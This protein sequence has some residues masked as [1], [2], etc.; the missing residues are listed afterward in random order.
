[1]SEPSILSVVRRHC[2]QGNLAAAADL[3][4]QLVRARFPL[5]VERVEIRQDG[6]SLNSVNGFLVLANSGAGRP[7]RLFFK[8]HQEEGEGDTIKEYYRGQLLKQH[9]F[10][11]DAP[12]HASQ[13]VGEQILIYA[14]RQC[15]RFADV[16]HELEQ[17][18]CPTQPV[19]EA[20][21]AQRRLDAFILDRYRAS[22]HTAGPAE[23][24]AEPVLQL[25]YW[26]LVDPANPHRLG[27]RWQQFYQG[28]AWLFPGLDAPLPYAD[29]ATKRWVI[30]GVAYQSPLVDLFT[31]AAQ[32]LNPR[33]L[34]RYPAVVAHGDAH[35]ANVWYSPTGADGQREL[36][37]FDPAFAGSHIPALLAEIKPTFHNIFAHPEWL[38]HPQ[39]A[40]AWLKAEARIEGETIVVSHNWQLNPLRRR[41]LDAKIAACW[42]P[43]LAHLQQ[44][45]LLPANWRAYVRA[46]LFCC[47]TLVM[48]LRAGAQAHTP[49]TSLL[50]LSIAVM[51]GSE[52]EPGAA[53]LVSD[54]LAAITP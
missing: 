2:K 24:E 42:R 46:A 45:G 27:G 7:P 3:L 53:D 33:H 17:Q 31:G 39:F 18:G 8:F 25:F 44:A 32:V 51:A 28:T 34:A 47:P 22:L 52:P 1:M 43:W 35:N 38:Y 14:E 41:F 37:L 48:N 50:G 20:D 29:F 26:R 40:D 23:L 11:V 21:G 10:P 5:D 16:C 15:P 12:L 6:Y 19:A 49:Q 30:N 13:A 36:L 54:F 4:A 9:G